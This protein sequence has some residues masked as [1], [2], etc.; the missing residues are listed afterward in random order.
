KT[1]IDTRYTDW[2]NAQTG[3]LVCVISASGLALAGMVTGILSLVLPDG[4]SSAF[5][6]TPTLSPENVGLRISYVF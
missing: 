1:D 5:N 2:Q 6:L 3:T 4:S